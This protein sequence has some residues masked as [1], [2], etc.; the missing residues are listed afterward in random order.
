M[1]SAV[2]LGVCVWASAS[3]AAD[4]EKEARD[5]VLKIA[6]LLEKG[7]MDDAKKAAAD[8]KSE[9]E[10]LMNLM[11]PRKANG[12]GGIGI[13]DKPG[14][15]TPDGIEKKVQALEKAAPPA[16]EAKALEKAGYIMQAIALTVENKVPKGKKPMPWKKY[17]EEY[18]KTAK[19]F[20][21]A[22]KKGDGKTIMAAAKKLNNACITCHNDYK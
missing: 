9:T 11:L 22:A 16:S 18:Q 1:V 2:V 17:N 15:I 3:N 4:D 8:V 6:D 21:D 13:G 14:A 20:T 7:K 10:D 12:K 19:D 5:A